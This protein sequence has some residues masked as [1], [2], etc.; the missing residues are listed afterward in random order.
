M[1]DPTQKA[2][3]LLQA[4]IGQIF[5]EDYTLRQEMNSMVEYA[6]RMLSAIEEYSLQGSKHG[7]VALQSLRLRRSLATSLWGRNDGV[8]NQL[9]GIGT[10][11]T[12]ILKLHGITT[13]E[14]V[15][16]SN[17]EM[18]EK[19]AHRTPPFGSNLRTVVSKILRGT[20]KLA[21]HLEYAAGSTTP[22]SLVCRLE[23]RN[24]IPRLYDGSSTT[25]SAPTVTYT[26]IA[27]TNKPGGCLFYKRDI[28][29]PETFKIDTPPKFGKITAVLLASLVGLDGKVELKGNEEMEDPPSTVRPAV[30][31]KAITAS[32]TNAAPRKVRN[33]QQSRVEQFTVPKR[34][35]G[36]KSSTG[37]TTTDTASS[38]KPPPERANNNV[39]PSP[40]PL[41]ATT[42]SQNKN[43]NQT[44]KASAS[45]K[46][47]HEAMSRPQRNLPSR[48]HHHAPAIE[49]ECRPRRHCNEEREAAAA[50][51]ARIQSTSENDRS[52][53]W[54]LPNTVVGRTSQGVIQGRS[55]SSQFP[56]SASTTQQISPKP[57]T[58]RQAKREQQKSQ[59][60]AFR[61]KKDNPFL[62]FKHDVSFGTTRVGLPAAYHESNI[63]WHH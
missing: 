56:A 53:T 58:W 62:Q 10:K 11:T 1:Q 50:D 12:A 47:P 24:D 25:S 33:F 38:L 51:Q 14:D 54:T 39:T 49:P 41:P 59:Q 6:S 36:A 8:L 17:D 43:V 46:R 23:P 57:A 34:S 18:I 45:S 30:S 9:L 3:V 42:A 55:S 63:E 16:A 37:R 19:A 44:A 52:G 4:S 21:A 28:S 7:H 31:K 20:F 48:P 61:R 40:K 27:Y 26:L 32:T 15:I 29:S 2:F 35:K 22:C 60:K 5:L 13:F